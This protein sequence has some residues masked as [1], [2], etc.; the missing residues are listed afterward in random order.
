MASARLGRLSRVESPD[1]RLRFD[2]VCCGSGCNSTLDEG[3]KKTGGENRLHSP[4]STLRLVLFSGAAT[5]PLLSSG[6][7]SP[8]WDGDGDGKGR[9]EGG[10]FRRMVAAVASEGAGGGALLA[11]LTEPCEALSFC[12]EDA[13]GYLSSP[14]TER[15][16]GWPTPRSPAP[17][18][19][20]SPC[21]PSP[22]GIFRNGE[23]HPSLLCDAAS[24]S[25]F[26]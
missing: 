26:H 25:L 18:R 20:C 7:A 14:R 15:L 8:S 16:C 24:S 10:K 5:P 23:K 11:S 22:A 12:T 13:G 1:L 3:Q 21:A 9:P 6:V 4:F 2:S 17:T 19:C